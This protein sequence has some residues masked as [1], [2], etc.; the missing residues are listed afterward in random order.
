MIRAEELNAG[1]K[2]VQVLFDINAEVKKNQI[3][4]IVGPNGS[5]KSTLLKTLFGLTNIYSGKVIYKDDDI[6]YTPP[7]D[8]TKLGIAYLPQVDNVFT[9][10][11]VEENLKIAGYTLDD[12]E[13]EERREIALNAFPE[14][15]DYLN[16]KAGTLSGGERQFLA[17]ATALIR[18]SELLMLD[19]PTA[20]LSP[21]F[22][23]IIFNKILELRDDFRLTIALVEQNV[24]R[25]LE[26]SEKAYLL[27]SG[28][29][30]FD[31]KARELLEHEKFERMCMGL[32]D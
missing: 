4:T 18:K 22:A 30:A 19:E 16:R 5:G 27:I 29:V 14:L 26:I 7:H 1:Y 31:G 32:L 21:K 24:K 10:L 6:T 12:G 20:Q 15:K 11:T 8:R 25:A 3:T 2:E 17:I 23:E 28:R 13:Y 9:N